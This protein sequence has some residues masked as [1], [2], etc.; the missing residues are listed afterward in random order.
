MSC[1]N[2]PVIVLYEI[3]TT[4]VSLPDAPSNNMVDDILKAFYETEKTE[5][6]LV[7]VPVDT[8]QSLLAPTTSSTSS[9]ATTTILAPEPTSMISETTSTSMS[10]VT[11]ISEPTSTSTSIA[12]NVEYFTNNITNKNKNNY[13]LFGI[14]LI[15][16][17]LIFLN[18]K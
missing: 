15:I 6:P 8:T 16:L 7:L 17:I 12:S 9:S 10:P 5:T 3:D 1:R 2:N 18:L 13:L 4:G 11:S 14:G